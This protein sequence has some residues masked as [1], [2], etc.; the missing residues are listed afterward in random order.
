MPNNAIGEFPFIRVTP[1][2][3]LPM[4]QWQR[5]VRAGVDNVT[6]FDT[7]KRGEVWQCSSVVDCVSLAEAGSLYQQYVDLVDSG[8]LVDVFYAGL[9]VQTQYKVL[10][11]DCLDMRRIVGGVGGIAGL[12]TALL[13]CQW[14]LQPIG[15][16]PVEEEEE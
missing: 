16:L 1:P 7:A 13:Q 3:K 8:E 6:L 2:P 4:S 12:S 9:Q 5:E 11:V 10:K 14:M 15:P